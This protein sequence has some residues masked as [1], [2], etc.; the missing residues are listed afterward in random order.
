MLLMMKQTAESPDRAQVINFGDERS[1]VE[2]G[3]YQDIVHRGRRGD[4][5]GDLGLSIEWS[6]PKPLEIRLV[7][8][9][10]SRTLRAAALGFAC[11]I[12]ENSAKGAAS[13]AVETFGYDLRDGSGRQL[14]RVGMRRSQQG[15]DLFSEGVEFKR[16]AGRPPR[17]L[18]P[19]KSYGFPDELAGVYQNVGFLNDIDLEFEELFESICY[20]GPLR[21]YPRRQY[22]WAG[23]RPTDVGRRGERVVDALLASRELGELIS[24]GY[25]M[26]R[27]TVEER[28]A[29]WLKTIGLITSFRVERISPESNLYRVRVQTRQSSS[30]SLPD[31]G[32]GVSQVLPVITLCYFAP[33]GSIII[34][35][36]PEIHLHPRVQ[37]A[38]ADVLIDAVRTRGV[39]VIV[40][41]HS[42]HLLARLQRRIAEQGIASEDVALYFFSR[43]GADSHIEPLDVDTYGN[44]TNWPADFFGDEISERSAM[45]EATMRR[46]D[47]EGPK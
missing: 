22:I 27:I 7:E 39:Q 10:T 26:R 43:G 30:V 3:S 4:P 14:A 18:I 37:A 8:S 35:E 11:E 24:P 36:Q 13:L 42:E 29:R 20:L 25:K 12:G 31:V 16:K 41:S 45:I 40:E 19:Y 33:E 15:A 6:L 34:L 17:S 46:L 38:L 44:I 47:R 32:F 2:L 9:P 28:V 23:G 1:Y 5:T 21:E